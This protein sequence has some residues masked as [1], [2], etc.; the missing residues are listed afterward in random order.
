MDT[1]HEIEIEIGLDGKIS[2]TV[3]GIEGASCS[4][5]SKWLDQLGEVIEDRKTDDWYKQTK[6]NLVRNVGR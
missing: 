5:I 1:K 2:S 3:K 4:E 6:Q